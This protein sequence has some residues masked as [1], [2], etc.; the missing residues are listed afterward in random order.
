MRL[1]DRDHSIDSFRAQRTARNG[2]VT[3]S[4]DGTGIVSEAGGLQ[5]TPGAERHRPGQGPEKALERWRPGR[6][7]HSRGRSSPARQ[8]ALALGGDCLADVAMLRPQPELY[9]R[10]LR[11]RWSLGCSRGLP[12]IRW[13]CSLVPRPSPACGY[14]TARPIAATRAFYEDGT[15]SGMRNPV[16]AG[17][18]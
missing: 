6:A 8:W 4:A 1:Y 15:G 14:T 12:S 2:K 3:A 16:R 17:L 18:P 9:G 10:W 11:I 5:L 13:S 7:V